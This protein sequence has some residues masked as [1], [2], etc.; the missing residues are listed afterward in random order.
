MS[1]F[2]ELVKVM[3]NLVAEKRGKSTGFPRLG[4]NGTQLQLVRSCAFLL[5]P[6]VPISKC[7]SAEVHWDFP[8]QRHRVQERIT[9]KKI[10]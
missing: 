4:T 9:F 1:G 7:Q 10:S 2:R 3:L 6:G 8:M 5:D